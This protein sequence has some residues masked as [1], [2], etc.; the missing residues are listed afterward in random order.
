MGQFLPPVKPGE[1]W[2]NDAEGTQVRANVTFAIINDYYSRL[3]A[4]NF[5]TF[6]YW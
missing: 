2:L 4:E 6:S 5:S 3:R 1:V